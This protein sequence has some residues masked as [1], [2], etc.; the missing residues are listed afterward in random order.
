MDNASII[1]NAALSMLDQ[2][3]TLKKRAKIK[4]YALLLA[5]SA[6]MGS[7]SSSFSGFLGIDRSAE[8]NRRMA[9]RKKKRRN[10]AR[11]VSE[12]PKRDPKKSEYPRK[13]LR[14]K[15]GDDAGH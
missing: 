13:H 3:P 2:C 1:F 5:S 7:C 9:G 11:A 14:K 4:E 10:A 15:A 8:A 12:I 6:A